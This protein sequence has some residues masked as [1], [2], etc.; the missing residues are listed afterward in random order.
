[1][2][3]K[4]FIEMTIIVIVSIILVTAVLVPIIGNASTGRTEAENEGATLF[5]LTKIGSSA[6]ANITITRA[7]NETHDDLITTVTNGTDSQQIALVETYTEHGYIPNG[8]IYADN[9]V[10]VVLIGEGGLLE[11]WVEQGVLNGYMLN[12]PATI[13]K[14]ASGVEITSQ[15]GATHTYPAPNWAYVPLS[16]GGYNSYANGTDVTI[17]SDF[18]DKVFMAMDSINQIACY[19]SNTTS[20]PATFN[21]DLDGTTLSGGSW[22][23]GEGASAVTVNCNYFIAPNIYYENGGVDTPVMAVLFVIPLLL[24][25]G[26]I[27]MIVRGVGLK[28]N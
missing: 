18:T 19:N 7:E 4:K 13:T 12:D 11:F 20:G 10:C 15:A 3:T 26:I 8:I 23:V 21:E 24:I 5:N 17:G 22:T 1:M 14:T 9:N 2:D 27:L 16:T 6:T 25:V 28:E